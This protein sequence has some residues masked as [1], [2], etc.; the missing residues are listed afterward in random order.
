[1]KVY[2]LISYLQTFNPNAEVHFKV[3]ETITTKTDVVKRVFFT[4]EYGYDCETEEQELEVCL[5]RVY[6][7]LDED[8]SDEKEVVFWLDGGREDE[9]A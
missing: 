7:E 2:E 8:R 1:M 5:D 6:S 9:N 4:D 3:Q